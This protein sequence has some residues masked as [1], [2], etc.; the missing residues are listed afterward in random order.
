MTPNVSG[1]DALPVWKLQEHELTT[2]SGSLVTFYG[3]IW[4]EFQAILWANA[5]LSVP[6]S[7]TAHRHLDFYAR[8]SSRTLGCKSEPV[9]SPRCALWTG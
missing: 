6:K 2:V 7:P 3:H 4:T 5:I 8:G 9:P 1:T